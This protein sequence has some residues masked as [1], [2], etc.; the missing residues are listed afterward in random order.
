MKKLFLLLFILVFMMG[1]TRL[2]KKH[3]D[4]EKEIVGK[5]YVLQDTEEDSEITINFSEG[6]LNG[7][8]GINMYFSSYKI[9]GNTISVGKAIGTTKMAGPGNLMIQE[10]DY[11]KNLSQVVSLDLK[12]NRLILTTSDETV[13]VFEEKT[14]N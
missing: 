5:T 4:I 1:C 13:L 6:R 2:I 8:A 14:E 11:L 3:V 9:S 10:M 7:N 12:G